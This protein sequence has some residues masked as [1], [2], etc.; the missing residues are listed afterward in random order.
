MSERVGGPCDVS[1]GERK[2]GRT[3]TEVLEMK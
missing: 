1:H 3:T 2:V